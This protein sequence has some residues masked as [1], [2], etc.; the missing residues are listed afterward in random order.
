MKRGIRQNRKK[1]LDFLLAKK[2]K[3]VCEVCGSQAWAVAE[4]DQ[5]LMTAFP[6]MVGGGASFGSSMLMYVAICTHC[7]HTRLH[8]QVTVDEQS[9]AD[10]KA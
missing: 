9:A 3:M 6:I 4:P 1:F 7:G 5:G 2:A 8:S 10:D